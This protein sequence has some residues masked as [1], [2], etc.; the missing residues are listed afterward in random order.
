MSGL[1]QNPHG[2]TSLSDLIKFKWQ[3]DE[4]EKFTEFGVTRLLKAENIGPIDFET[5]FATRFVKGSE[6][7]TILDDNFYDA[8]LVPE[9]CH[10]PSDLG[11]APV[12]C[13][14]LGFHPKSTPVEVDEY[15]LT[16]K[17]PGMP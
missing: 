2:V 11:Q 12:I 14:R 17:G 10:N 13:L 16:T 9:G 3:H 8:I 7:A 4:R 1:A 15:G 5:E 6:I